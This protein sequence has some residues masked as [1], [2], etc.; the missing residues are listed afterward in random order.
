MP[1]FSAFTPFGHL[2]FSGKPSHGES[3][4]RTLR[5]NFGDVFT[6]DF[7]SVQQARLYAQAMC[8]AA[9]QYTLDR[10][11]NNRTPA[12]AT[13]LLPALEKDHQ[14]IPSPRS[15]LNQR[16][17][18]LSAFQKIGRGNRRE[19]VEDALRTLLGSAFIRYT[20]TA[21]A[22]IVATP[23]SPEI[24]GVFAGPGAKKKVFAI[25]QDVVPTLSVAVLTVPFT[26]LGGTEAPMVGEKYCVD[27]DSRSPNIEQITITGVGPGT[28]SAIFLRAHAAGTL[29]VRPH[30][31][32]ISNQRVNT[33]VVTQAAAQD[34]E[35]R[36]KINE[37]MARIAR[38]VSIWQIVQ[39]TTTGFFTSD[40][41]VLGLPDIN[42][43][44]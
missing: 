1:R 12:K 36:R 38:S 24:P 14:V 10:A 32:W 16:R 41:P 20:T 29:A 6:T 5:D 15:T 8:L 7:N 35:T 43:V 28:I 40:D 30:P 17:A 22:D 13:E 25:T 31:Y 23:A 21:P 3:I 34:P 33:I 42:V 11:Y 9:S 4:Y 27:P 37:L 2:A 44:Q 39:G 18:Y 19:A 26:S